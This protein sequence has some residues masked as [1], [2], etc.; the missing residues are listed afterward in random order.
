MEK[1]KNPRNSELD[2]SLSF[3][4]GKMNPREEKNQ[5][6]PEKSAPLWSHPTWDPWNFPSRK[7]LPGKIL[8]EFREGGT[9]KK[10][11][12]KKPWELLE[13]NPELNFAF[14]PP[15]PFS[16]LSFLWEKNSQNLPK[17]PFFPPGF[18]QEF[19]SSTE[20]L[21][22]SLAPVSSD[23][24]FFAEVP[25]SIRS[26]SLIST[27]S[28]ISQHSPK[29]SRK[30][31]KNPGISTS[32]FPQENLFQLNKTQ[33]NPVGM[34]KFPPKIQ[35]GM[36]KFPFFPLF[37]RRWKR[38]CWFFPFGIWLPKFW[39][40]LICLFFFHFF[41]LPANHSSISFN[42]FSQPPMKIP[43]KSQHFPWFFSPEWALFPFFSGFFFEYFPLFLPGF[44][45][46]TC[47]PWFP[48]ALGFFGKNSMIFFGFSRN[49]WIPTQH[50]SW[51][52]FSGIIPTPQ[53]GNFCRDLI[54]NFQ[55]VQ[56]P[57]AF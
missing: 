42:S 15:F 49:S 53:F 20:S 40:G 34:R 45:V 51:W 44:L 41:F 9:K 22:K 39:L 21:D 28:G 26:I 19:S 35:L 2:P 54:P 57:A 18:S 7:F 52:E 47:S 12:P 10:D 8:Q 37:S 4:G 17:S 32:T 36:R 31:K 30:I 46:G 3:Q 55:L 24:V 5:E 16:F 56:N 48:P 33:K 50:W 14:S 13:E 38:K 29:Y 11:E 27:R 43:I 1:V 6:N 23:P 25:S